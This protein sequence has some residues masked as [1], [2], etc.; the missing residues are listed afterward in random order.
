MPEIKP[1]YRAV[2]DCM[3]YVQ[4]AAR[5]KSP[6]NA[7]F[8]LVEA[9]IVRLYLSREILAEIEDVLSR[10]QLRNRFETLTDE[11]VEAFLDDIK[12]KARILKNVPAVIQYPRDPKDE[13]YVNLAI[14]VEADFIVSRDKDLLDLMTHV[15][16]DAKEFRQKSRPLKIVEPIEFLK[17]IKEKFGF[18]QIKF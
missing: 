13:K 9:G 2:F 5:V 17:I 12:S 16:A 14:E 3:I 6:A 10:T 11:K 7:C 1:F 4:A 15:S 18:E 8:K